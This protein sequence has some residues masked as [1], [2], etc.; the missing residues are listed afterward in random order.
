MS[1]T[2]IISVL[3]A[4]FACAAPA[5]TH[6]Q[7]GLAD[8][9]EPTNPA[10]PERFA[11]EFRFGPYTP[12]TGD[13]AFGSVFGG[14]SL[15]V[16]AEFD[17]VPFRIRN[18]LTLGIGAGLGFTSYS[19]KALA[20]DGTPTSEDTS[21]SLV[22]MNLMAVLRIIALPRLLSIPFIFTGKLGADIVYWSSTTGKTQDGSGISPGL[23]WAVQAALE[24]DFFEPR[25][26][27]ALDDEWGINH[28]FLYFELYGSTAGGS[29]LPVGSPLAWALGLGMNF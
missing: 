9:S 16:A 7:D 23:R 8:W 26:A 20:P 3:A 25:A 27:R 11:L 14:S 18:V 4:L 29:S 12:S 28:T 21:L 1:R 6:A 2:I 5:L 24:L 19:G 22:P 10:S 17:V 15:L 13:T